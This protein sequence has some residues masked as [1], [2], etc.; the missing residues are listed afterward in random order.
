MAR[1]GSLFGVSRA[2]LLEGIAREAQQL[3]AFVAYPH[4]GE[5]PALALLCLL[6]AMGLIAF[7]L[8]VCLSPSHRET[9]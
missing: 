4:G 6:R 3:L 8:L 1:K 9:A 7:L 2:L 5:Y